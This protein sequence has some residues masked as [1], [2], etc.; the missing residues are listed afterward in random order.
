MSPSEQ[1]L[2]IG[3]GTDQYCDPDLLN[4]TQS[5]QEVHRIAELVGD[6]YDKHLLTDAY[7]AEV[8]NTLR[9]LK[10]RFSVA[11][12]SVF[13]MWSGHGVP[14]STGRVRLLVADSEN[15]IGSGFDPEEVASQ[16]VVTGANQILCIL[17]TCH[18]GAALGVTIQVDDL[19]TRT[20]TTSESTWVGVLTSCAADE[21]VREQT[22]G[23]ALIKL[24]SN[25]PDPD[26]PHAD[27]LRRRWNPHS[28][29]IRGDDLCEAVLKQWDHSYGALPHFAQAGSAL[30]MVR[31]PLW[32][33]TAAPTLVQEILD[34]APARRF[35]GRSGE[36]DIVQSWAL[37]N[38]PG[39]FVI[40]GRPGSGK[41]ALLAQA[42]Q[43]LGHK[44]NEGSVDSESA[45]SIDLCCIQ[46]SARGLDQ[47]SLAA[48]IEQGLIA[49]GVLNPLSHARNAFELVGSLERLS[50]PVGDEC[51]LPVIAVD[52]LSEAPGHL[53]G[54]IDRLLVPMSECAVVVVT[55]RRT[56]V[57]A[58]AGSSAAGV[59]ARRSLSAQ[60]PVS[61][62]DVTDVITSLDRILDL[63]SA[64]H[65]SSGWQSLTQA[66]DERLSGVYESMDTL[67]VA[68]EIQRLVGDQ[69]PPPFL[70]MELI[71]DRLVDSPIDTSKSGWQVNMTDSIAESLDHV[72]REAVSVD[73]SPRNYS[74]DDAYHLL[75]ALQWGLGAGFPEEHWI[76]V[77][78]ATYP[79]R[80]FTREDIDWLFGALGKY[81]VEDSE[82]GVAVYRCAHPLIA[83]HF[84]TRAT[85][86]QVSGDIEVR[87]AQALLDRVDLSSVSADP[88]DPHLSRYLWRYLMRAG[89]RGLALLRG[90]DVRAPRHAAELA[91]ATLGVSI[92]AFDSAD[93]A[94]ATELAEATIAQL[95][96]SDLQHSDPVYAQA[97]AHLALCYQAS[98]QVDQAVR[99]AGAAV[100]IYAQ[101]VQHDPD[102]L[103][104]YAAVVHNYGTILMDAGR[105]QAA[106]DATSRAADQERE[107]LAHGGNNHYR[108]GVTLNVLA[109]AHS[110]TL[111][112]AEAVV[113]SRDSVGALRRAVELRNRV[114]DHIALAESLSNLGSHLA[115]IGDLQSGLSSAE[116]AR[117]ILEQ[118]AA[119]E[120]ALESKLAGAKNDLA[121]R[122]MELGEHERA[123]ALMDEVIET[124]QSIENPS[125]KESTQFFGALNNC[126]AVLLSAGSTMEAARR[127][128]AAVR[129][130]RTIAADHPAMNGELAMALD[131][132]ANCLTQ[133][134]EHRA[135][136]QL[137]EEALTIY[138]D[139]ASQNEGEL[140]H[141]ARVLL[142]YGDRL[143]NVGRP[144]DAVVATEEAR[145][146]YHTLAASNA[147]FEVEVARTMAQLAV[148]QRAAHDRVAA[149]STAAQAVQLFDD[150]AVR[151][152]VDDQILAE[153]LADTL[154]QATTCAQ[155]LS[156]QLE[157]A[158]RAVS[159]FEAAGVL[160]SLRYA[161]ALR[162]LA[163]I[164][165]TRGEGAA[166]LEA[167]KRA[168]KVFSQLAAA[169][170]TV[171]A[172]LAS[173]LGIQA[174]LEFAQS[175][176]D[177][178]I[179]AA[180]DAL[181][182]YERL[183]EL[184]PAN[185]ATCAEA[186]A[187]LATD[188]VAFNPQLPIAV[189]V[190]RVLGLLEGVQRALL[191]GE[192]VSRLPH[193]SP[194]VPKWIVRGLDELGD[195][196]PA[197]LFSLRMLARRK[198]AAIPVLFDLAWAQ[199][200]HASAPSWLTI[201][202]R[203][204]ESALEWV[205]S[206]T[207]REGYEY[208]RDHRYLVDSSFD[209]IIEEAYLGITPERVRILREI[210]SIAA[211]SG[212]ADA[213]Q[214][215][216][217]SDTADAFA[218]TDL[219]G[220]LELLAANGEELRS[221]LVKEHLRD[222]ATTDDVP[223]TI[224]YYLIRLSED[225]L[226][227]AVVS[228]LSDPDAAQELLERIARDN[229]QPTLVR[230][231]T[232]L[233]RP[234]P[235]R[236]SQPELA[237]VAAFYL[238]AILMEQGKQQEAA[239]MID[240]V[241]E[242]VPG[243]L[244]SLTSAAARLG[245][246]RPEF[247]QLIPLLIDVRQD[248]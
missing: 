80:N 54:I 86:D 60:T 145:S 182:H 231:T 127:G 18:S 45:L 112:D 185:I 195:Q 12:G 134:S 144:E 113:A 58:P 238:S 179:Q 33:P 167:I 207:H 6:H 227:V 76:A 159:A 71:C 78:K 143:A 204:L 110:A 79:Q 117:Q 3:V 100:G 186:L 203:R 96:D 128:D 114:C 139:I 136:I 131:N 102:L 116:E 75:E 184:T 162:N 32:S 10:G 218:A 226:H 230:A 168:V 233:L 217:A 36:V 17:D 65:R 95:K 164:H 11:G 53:E 52:G 94:R 135:A 177:Q 1:A 138:R 193:L 4:L 120:P 55:T 124:L 191:L 151:K 221:E 27:L 101:L 50:H 98:G 59:T 172:E 232:V 97:H 154:V 105:P 64:T 176:P 23:P 51:R 243:R 200:T 20:G 245:S 132:F 205:S 215:P 24:L 235:P 242:V 248:N 157:Y 121:A 63:D 13:L 178:G 81:V 161:M 26:G 8:R 107:F 197:T 229:D 181:A 194:F 25:G 129:L 222:R 7:H 187:A 174:R 190:D 22:L 198:R 92:N 214:K 35:V 109:L 141:V 82:Q 67:A 239:S 240:S 44:P 89:E 246:V 14:A 158:Q 247:L 220:Q 150:L 74:A 49:S 149:A 169:G 211:V 173:A 213:Y 133:L 166:G 188:G 126:C 137:T 119:A 99:S 2:F 237:G 148:H 104:D 208:L 223:G 41:T 70:L 16:C 130:A 118:V 228:A 85:I 209:S 236:A 171:E 125:L 30:P 115:S 122:L 28:E 165:G 61:M 163:A 48:R 5:T 39:I 103:A 234:H 43:Q 19:F 90:R 88:V 56:E 160:K 29:F 40:T 66:V 106:I 175:H 15:D 77:A 84:R 147:R 142:N 199:A 37:A 156:L 212:I 170:R 201:D 244:V 225:E 57:R 210:R 93:V 206:S 72:V 152:I 69:D 87:V 219:N 73:G 34:G 62:L 146:L 241:R 189:Y 38:E 31:N 68:L 91:Y 196:S 202:L 9:A 111:H 46:V 108:L 224:A 153:A 83:H 123:L 180:L 155:D 21:I 183:P 42:M 47:L 140:V 216:L 192:I